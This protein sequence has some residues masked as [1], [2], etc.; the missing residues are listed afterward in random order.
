MAHDCIPRLHL[1]C[2]DRL[3]ALDAET[4]QCEAVA[5]KKDKVEKRQEREGSHVQRWQ[6]QHP[7]SLQQHDGDFGS[8]EC[9]KGARMLKLPVEQKNYHEGSLSDR[10]LQARACSGR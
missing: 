8:M 10:L 3:R 9:N 4:D 5:C 6:S 7:G 1:V 2:E